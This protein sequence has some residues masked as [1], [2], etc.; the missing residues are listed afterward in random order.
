MNEHKT[1]RMRMLT[2]TRLAAACAA[3]YMGCAYGASPVWKP[4]QNVEVIVGT[5]PGIA[6]SPP[7]RPPPKPTM[8][9]RFHVIRLRCVSDGRSSMVP[10]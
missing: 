4:E 8:M 7:T 10:A 1:G 5:A 3:M 9:L 6:V 2:A